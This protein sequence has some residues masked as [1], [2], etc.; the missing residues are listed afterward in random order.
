MKH[1]TLED[2]SGAD[3]VDEGFVA[4]CHLFE[5]PIQHGLVRNF[6]GKSLIL[7]LYCRRGKLLR[8]PSTQPVGRGG[9]L[10]GRAAH[11]QRQPNNHGID[12]VF[13]D[14]RLQPR[15]QSVG[16]NGLQT[17]GNRARRVANRHSGALHAIVYCKDSRH[18]YITKKSS[19]W[20]TFCGS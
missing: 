19:K 9:G 20:M 11:L 8:K 15:A 18:Y 12:V 17:T 4:A 2:N 5:T 16:R 13:S 1:V 10:R 3:A 7:P 6:R 14:I